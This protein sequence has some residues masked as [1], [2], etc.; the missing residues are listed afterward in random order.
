MHRQDLFLAGSDT[1]SGTVDWAMSELLRDPK[2]MS[3][4]KAEI[5]SVVGEKV[6]VE[7]SDISRLPY[8]QAVIKET[9]RFHPLAPFLV[10]HEARS[11][12]EINGYTIPKNAQILVNVYAS[13]R[14]PTIWAEADKFMPERFLEDSM[15]SIDFR[16]SDFELIPFGAG[17]RICPALPL[18][19]RMV[20]LMLATFVHNFDWK[21]ENGMA[22]EEIDMND[23]FGLSLQR[24]VPLRA[25]PVLTCD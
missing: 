11:T 16:G 21:L 20:H 7:E 3:I 12:I 2:K 18:A 25:I 4:L 1:T 13:G 5:N 17:R 6:Q 14:D 15:K 22:P 10:P 24:A 19:N 23:K 8:L 9:F